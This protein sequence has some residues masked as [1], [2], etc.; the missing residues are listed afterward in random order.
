MGNELIVATMAGLGGMLGWGLA[1]FFAK[2]TIDDIGDIV[3]LAWAHVFGSAA[4]AIS[5][6]YDFLV[7]NK[8]PDMNYGLKT[9]S[10]LVFF[11]V[12]QAVI[13]LLLY[14]SF[15]KGYVSVLAPI[16]SSF[17][18]FTA[19]LSIIILGEIVTGH[20]LFGLLALFAG[21][22]LINMD[23]DALKARRIGFV[24]IPGLKE[25]LAATAFAVIW[26]LLW[27]QFV[28]N[29]DWL[30]YTLFMYLFM[31]IAIL[32]YAKI[33]SIKLLGVKKAAWKY[34][35]VIGVFEIVAYLSIS[36]GYSSTSMTSVVALLSGAF[37]LPTI[38]LARIFLQERLSFT[39][40]VGGL[41]VI[42]GIMFLS[43]FQ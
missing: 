4:L 1:D 14:N 16:F 41:V 42:V 3:T 20:V 8:F 36:W 32:V 21:I 31:T 35:F 27:D 10:L 11:G 15:R 7:L 40:L 22:L 9:W 43:F 26:T 19:A 30:L 25:V 38:F 23:S 33:S 17:S 5:F 18:G 29:K 12:V 34:L 28:G 2:K 13:Y 39:Q 6:G 24:N 37:S